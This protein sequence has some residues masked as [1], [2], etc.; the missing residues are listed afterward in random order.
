MNVSLLVARIYFSSS[1]GASLA[2]LLEELVLRLL[3]V[4]VADLPAHRDLVQR[5]AGDV[6]EP[7]LDQ[8]PLVPAPS[9]DC[10]HF[11]MKQGGGERASQKIENNVSFL[12][13]RI[14]FSSSSRLSRFSLR[15]LTCRKTPG[16]A[17]ECAP[18][19]RPRRSL[20][21]FCGTEACRT[22]PTEEGARRIFNEE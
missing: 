17:P 13:A 10:A 2:N 9:E 12:V 22:A 7:V 11:Y 4:N 21:L 6:N 8:L 1:S 14:Y 20:L 5:R 19:P 15:S 18:R 3:V 16:A